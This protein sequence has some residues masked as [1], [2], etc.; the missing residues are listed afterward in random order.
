MA[1]L[2]PGGMKL[3]N[4]TINVPAWLPFLFASLCAWKSVRLSLCLFAYL[5]P[6]QPVR[7]PHCIL[8]SLSISLF[9]LYA[10]IYQ[11]MC[12]LV[13]NMYSSLYIHITHWPC[14]H[15]SVVCHCFDNFNII[16]KQLILQHHNKA[17]N[18][19]MHV[20]LRS[21]ISPSASSTTTSKRIPTT[22]SSP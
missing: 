16:T 15:P 10:L 12:L 4:V 13:C 20:Y 6:I 9:L 19:P 1:A 5:L 3:N 22:V 7:W 21:Q 17:I 11:L 14:E 8:P 2:S 18:K